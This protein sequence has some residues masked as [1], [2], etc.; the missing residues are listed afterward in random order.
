MNIFFSF[1]LKV[2]SWAG[3]EEKYFRSSLIPVKKQQ[4]IN[5]PGWVGRTPGLRLPVLPQFSGMEIDYKIT[6][7]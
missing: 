6:F 3:S 1:R 2:G 5:V 7:K 4:P